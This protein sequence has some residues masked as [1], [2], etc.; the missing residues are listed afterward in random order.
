[1]RD[2]VLPMAILLVQVVLFFRLP[3]FSAEWLI[4][5]DL[6]GYHLPLA[7]HIVESWRGGRFPW[8]DNTTYCGFPFYANVQTQLFY[9]GAWPFFAAGL[10][11]GAD[12]MLDVLEWQVALHVWLAGVFAFVFGRRGL[13]ASIPAALLGAT[14]FQLGGFFASQ[15]QHLGVVCT[16][17]WLPWIWLAAIDGSTRRAA[18]G[19]AMAWLAGYPS[20]AL[21]AGV[22]GAL[23]ASFGGR[24]RALAYAKAVPWAAAMAA[25]QLLPAAELA[26]LSG[27]REKAGFT[28]TGGGVPLQA[29]IS[30]VWP[31][32]HRI[33]DATAYSLPWNRSYLYL[34]CGLLPLGAALLGLVRR[35]TPLWLR[36]CAALFTVWMLGETTPLWRA[37]FPAL[38]ARELIVP[39]LAIMAFILAV[40]AAAVCGV[41]GLPDRTVW[42]AVA[43]A[44]ADLTLAGSGN[45][46]H[47]GRRADTPVVTPSSFEGSA[48]TLRRLREL[49]GGGSIRPPWRIDVLNDSTN[50]A[51]SGPVH[52]IP[53][54]TGNDPLAL[55]RVKEVRR[56]FAHGDAWMHYYTVNKPASPVLDFLNV[57][58]LLH[59]ETA[60]GAALPGHELRENADALPRFF[61]VNRT[62]AAG[63][64]EEIDLRSEA[65]VEGT[66]PWANPTG[67]QGAVTVE[68]YGSSRVRLRVNAP[69]GGAFLVTS[70]AH[71]PGWQAAIDGAPAPIAITN[72]A[73]RGLA[74]P[75]G[76]HLVTMRFR[77]WILA[78]GAALTAAAVLQ[79]GRA[80]V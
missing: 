61:L 58:Y 1:M 14:I 80:H 49:T 31:N 70:E 53:M 56:L 71:Y 11:F 19:L 46:L 45:S 21:V 54:A 4:P 77:P 6:A 67:G 28:G 8:W 55:A 35:G 79:I 47:T 42:A 20:A 65:L 30:M 78:W 13:G 18:V 7:T 48:E 68:L 16:A 75:G 2:L 62:V 73:F 59:W 44:W 39:E 60:P 25:L 69:S 10:V 52:A 40:A 27:A 17:A 37:I 43:I 26:G 64:L 72:R 74:V 12:R 51:A 9:P 22:S 24:D 63:R 36:V 38:P 15:A 34:Y 41:R 33:F 29:F 3:L 66:A 23:V 76:E 32:Y 57:R 5:Y 50:W